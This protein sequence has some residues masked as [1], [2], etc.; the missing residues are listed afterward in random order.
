RGRG[1]LEWVPAMGARYRALFVAIELV[2]LVVFTIEYALRV[3]VAG[4][5]GLHRHD[6]EWV[7]RWRYISSAAGIIDLLAVL[8]FWFAFAVP[9][10]LR[11]ILVFRIVRFLK[12]ARYSPGMR[13]LL[14]V[15]NAER[16][17]L[18][19]CFV[20]LIGMTVLFGAAMHLVEGG[21]QP[22]KF[23]TIPDAMWWALVTLST[24]GGD[25]A[26]LTP[27]GR[28]LGAVTIFFSLIMIALPGGIVATSFADPPRH[29]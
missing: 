20:V 3:W 10:D 6:G 24:I 4:E 13:S 1:R 15:L 12:L 9:A 2:S 16:R 8:P 29:R 11:V 17:A 18:A 25:A 5:H 22:N 7:A 21:A 27:L 28:V 14:D 19:G 26:P 23:G